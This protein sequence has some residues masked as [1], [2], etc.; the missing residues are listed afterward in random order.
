MEILDNLFRR[1]SGKMI[2][3]LAAVFGI[4]NLSLAEDV[5]QEA[6]CRAIQVWPYKGVPDN[7]AAWLMATARNRALDLLRRERTARRYAPEFG[8]FLESEWTVSQS[9]NQQFEPKAISG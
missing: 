3:V 7:P 8:K 1:E 2:S 4:H 9:L 5:V 6:F